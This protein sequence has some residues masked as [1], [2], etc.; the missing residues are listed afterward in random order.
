VGL[1][2]GRIVGV[3]L[4]TGE[5]LTRKSLGSPAAVAPTCRGWSAWVATRDNALH[6][7]RLHARRAGERWRVLSGADPAAPAIPFK[8][9]VL[10]LSKDTFLYGFRKSN[11][12]LR[13]RLRLDRR[14]GPGAILDDLLF[15]AGPQSTRLDAFRLPE[16]RPAGSY[17]LPEAARFVTPP[18]ASAGRVAVVVGRY[19][20]ETSKLVGLAPRAGGP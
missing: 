5:I 2:D 3:D 19:G 13:F 8:D 16:G 14:P 10:F 11:G 20:E 7:L 4:E 1:E 18:V 15:V 9:D 12:H 17:T 6:S